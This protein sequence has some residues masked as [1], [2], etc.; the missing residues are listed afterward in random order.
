MMMNV[1]QVILARSIRQVAAIFS[2][3]YRLDLVNRLRDRYSF[4]KV[5][6]TVDELLGVDPAE[7]IKFQHGKFV[8]DDRSFV[9]ELLQ[10]LASPAGTPIIVCDTR[11]STDDC[12]LFLDDYVK[13]A[14]L[15]RPDVITLTEPT[16]YL[17]QIEFT[18]ERSIKDLCRSP[19]T[20]VGQSLHSMLAGYGQKTP[21]FEPTGIVV[22]F[23][24]IGFG[25]IPPAHFSLERRT[26]FRHEANTYFS[27]APLRTQ[28]HVAVLKHLA[29]APLSR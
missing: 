5:P 19:L 20:D 8:R 28:D 15:A 13:Q 21:P 25:G 1:R 18:M 14:N 12:D 27:Q 24:Q 11:T 9:V 23:D 6:T 26:G 16:L 3:D 17:S 2:L 29:R 4:I 7:G 10:F 22:N